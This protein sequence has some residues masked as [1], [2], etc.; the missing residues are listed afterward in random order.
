MFGR[1]KI[2]MLVAEFLGAA[3]LT[4]AVYAMAVRT[5]FPFFSAAAGGLTVGLMVLLVGAVSG[6]HINPAVTIGMWTLHKIETAQALVYVVAQVLGGLA[7]WRFIEYLLG[8]PLKDIAGKNVD[9]HIM[10]AEGVGAL[11]FGWGVAVAA[12]R[13][14]DNGRRALVMGSAYFIGVLVAAFAANGLLNPAVAVGVRSVSVSYI[15]APVVGVTV[16]ML[17]HNYLFAMSG[18]VSALSGRSAGRR[19]R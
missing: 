17:I 12:G 13:A 1:Q 4:T 2:A 5:S 15:V 18:T 14:Y 7:A 19:R 8:S 3:T 6:A 11:I 16:G 9:W 10:I